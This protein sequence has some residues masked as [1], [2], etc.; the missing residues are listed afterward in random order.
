M[1]SPWVAL[2]PWRGRTVG[3]TEAKLDN[4]DST[5]LA[6]IICDFTWTSKSSLETDLRATGL[7]E[8]A[9]VEVRPGLSLSVSKSSRDM[10]LR[11]TGLESA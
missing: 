11:V 6:L 5:R 7:A 3:S 9:A 8:E 2:L 1:N 10:L 4:Q